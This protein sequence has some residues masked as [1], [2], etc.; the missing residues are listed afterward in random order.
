[1]RTSRSSRRCLAAMV[2][3]RLKPRHGACYIES[4]F[5][6]NTCS[7]HDSEPGVQFP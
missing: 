5:C 3:M 2:H 4:V 6:G 7:H 1:M